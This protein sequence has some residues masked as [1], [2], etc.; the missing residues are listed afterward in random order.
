MTTSPDLREEHAASDLAL[1][2]DR[3]L[4][5]DVM[6]SIAE[7]LSEPDLPYKMDVIDLSTVEPAFR[8][9]IA[10][11]WIPFETTKAGE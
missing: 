7:A 2:W 4:S 9:R 10:A 11:G 6:A 1:E 8:A 5:L 3:P